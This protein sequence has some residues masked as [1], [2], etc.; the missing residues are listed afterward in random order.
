MKKL[1]I[2]AFLAGCNAGKAPADDSFDNLAGLD[3]K[4]DAF[5]AYM[6]VVG[7]I[8]PGQTSSTISYSK[9]PRYRAFKLTA[10]GPG[11]LALTVHSTDG[12]DA[13]TWLLDSKY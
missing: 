1:L 2:L 4:S 6:K 11:T 5:S 3:E 10:K 8:T 7:S 9:G 12:G 13:L